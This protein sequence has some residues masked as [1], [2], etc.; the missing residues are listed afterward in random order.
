MNYFEVF[1]LHREL[2]IDTV[3]L[4]ARF[5]ELSRRWHPDV[6]Q[7]A[8]ADEQA[9]ALEQSALLNAAYRTLRDPI[10]RAEYLV[11]LAEGRETNEGSVVRPKAPPELLEEVFEVQEMLR[12]AQADGLSRESRAHLLT[13][14]DRLGDRCRAEE[15]R[16][17]GPLA[18]AW[19]AAAPVERPRVLD[20]IKETLA[21][22]AYLRTV[23]DDLT[24]AL[25]ESQDSH[26]A[27]R[28]H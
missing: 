25:D 22:R 27:H 11:R 13:E 5:Y 24:T 15:D 23:V 21:A 8:P 9:R 10:A 18:A 3:V 16:L 19:D 2:G 12:D 14:R 20:A 6:Q 17:R 26:V 1:G 28:R 4:Q 7:G